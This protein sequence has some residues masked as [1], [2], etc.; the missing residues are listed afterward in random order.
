MGVLSQSPYNVN[1]CL[2]RH[3]GNFCLV[4]ALHSNDKVQI[5]TIN[6]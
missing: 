1:N 6:T 5:A 3:V 4:A 2:T